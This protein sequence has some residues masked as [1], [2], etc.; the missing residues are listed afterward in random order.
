[1]ATSS[2]S[3]DAILTSIIT[4]GDLSK[5][6]QE[7]KV[8]HYKNFC[9]RLGLDPTTQPF[10]IIRLNGKE[11]MYC[12]RTGTQQLNKLHSV[13]H[14]IRAREIV[15]GCYVVTC[16]A[17]TPDGRHT[18]SIGAVPIENLR[19]DNLCNA[20]M[21]SETKSKRRAT[22][23]LLGLGVLDETETDAIPNVDAKMGAPVAA[24]PEKTMAEAKS[25]LKAPATTPAT[26]PAFE[27]AGLAIDG[28]KVSLPPAPSK[29]DVSAY[30]G[31]IH[32]AKTA[33]DALGL[34][35]SAPAAMRQDV[36]FEHEVY[37]HMAFAFPDEWDGFQ[38]SR[39]VLAEIDKAQS[40]PALTDLYYTHMEVFEKNALLKAAL[41]ARKL[42]VRN[43]AA[44]ATGA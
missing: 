39:E 13:S 20:M 32:A 19:G 6:T 17:S 34:Y 35:L 31:A 5:L 36:A 30:L 23:D 15:N 18:E 7:Q 43:E 37:D 40:I 21:K 38:P 9:E 25:P 33:K 1:M 16:Q 42:L 14:E 27:K 28:N 41:S 10:K 29:E 2:P 44:E 3:N 4:N 26:S 24:V 22:L 11:I 12:D 8:A